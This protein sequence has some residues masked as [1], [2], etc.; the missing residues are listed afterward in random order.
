MSIP[1]WSI[2]P[3]N[4]QTADGTGDINNIEFMLYQ[5]DTWNCYDDV[6]AD[7][8]NWWSSVYHDSN[9]KVDDMPTTSYNTV[10]FET[11]RCWKIPGSYAD[12]DSTLNVT[13]GG[14]LTEKANGSDDTYTNPYSH[15]FY[16]TSF[17][18]PSGGGHH[19]IEYSTEEHRQ[20]PYTIDLYHS[21]STSTGN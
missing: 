13:F 20:S 4:G 10:T 12:S 2:L 18:A 6:E 16:F 17:K 15:F 19:E 3:N 11:L 5:Y 9:D 21:L 14:D 8:S 1:Y 7:F